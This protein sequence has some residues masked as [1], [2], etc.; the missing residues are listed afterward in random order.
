MYSTNIIHAG[1]D[2]G[3]GIATHHEWLLASVES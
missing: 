2:L 3:Q 1:V